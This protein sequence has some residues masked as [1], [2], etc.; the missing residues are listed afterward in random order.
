MSQENVELVGRVFEWVNR[1]DVDRALKEL[2]DDFEVDWSNSIGPVK[3]VYRGREQIRALLS[4]FIE[5]FDSWHWDPQE[6]IE[7][8]ESQLIVINHTRQRGRGSGVEV[9]ATGAQLWMF[10]G[11]K[12]MRLKLYQSKPDALEAVGLSQ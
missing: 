6:F 11:G 1:G 7:V 5:A 9:T 12:A 4:S 10:A 3:G 2:P 8:D